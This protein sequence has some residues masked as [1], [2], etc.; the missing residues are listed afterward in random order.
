MTATVSSN[1]WSS[2]HIFQLAKASR[3]LWVYWI[4]NRIQGNE[5]PLKDLDGYKENNISENPALKE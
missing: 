4:L 3:P 2:F 1:E 5:T